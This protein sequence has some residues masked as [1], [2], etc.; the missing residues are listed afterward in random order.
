MSSVMKSEELM[1]FQLKNRTPREVFNAL[2]V[3][4]KDY[5][6]RAVWFEHVVEDVVGRLDER[7]IL[8]EDNSIKE[9]VAQRY[10]YQGDYDC[11]LSY[12]DN[13]DNLIDEVLKNINPTAITQEIVNNIKSELA[14]NSNV[15]QDNTDSKVFQFLSDGD[16]E[17]PDDICSRTYL[18]TGDI[19]KLKEAELLWYATLDLSNA[20]F[21]CLDSKKHL[22]DIG[23]EYEEIEKVFNAFSESIS[24]DLFTAYDQCINK[25]E[26]MGLIVSNIDDDKDIIADVV[27]SYGVY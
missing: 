13:I 21:R 9:S 8:D 19:N 23:Y 18:I 10:V 26:M 3:E 6:Y 15:S 5:I 7:E 2:S 20:K 14:K 17:D 24:E 4:Q 1:L 12:W 11:N 27:T 16:D 25:F 22:E